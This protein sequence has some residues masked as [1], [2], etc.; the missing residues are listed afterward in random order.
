[1][2]ASSPKV[3]VETES[4][5]KPGTVVENPLFI[6]SAINCPWREGMTITMFHNSYKYKFPCSVQSIRLFP[7]VSV[8]F[9]RWFYRSRWNSG[10]P[11]QQSM[12]RRKPALRAGTHS[13]PT[14]TP[15]SEH[16]PAPKT[17]NSLHG[18][19][20]QTGSKTRARAPTRSCPSSQGQVWLWVQPVP[21]IGHRAVPRTN[22]LPQVTPHPWALQRC[23]HGLVYKS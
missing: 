22:T 11:T 23:R 2:N 12:G 5:S 9:Q 17:H 13:V 15:L 14:Q 19:S 1:M 20:A 16:R 3:P 21:N 10:I 6:L 4:C 7:H 18:V 8:L